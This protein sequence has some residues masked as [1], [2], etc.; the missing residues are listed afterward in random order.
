MRGGSGR[1]SSTL[2]RRS[3][4]EPRTVAKVLA[5]EGRSCTSYTSHSDRALENVAELDFS[6]N[7]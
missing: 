1:R 6:E 2:L 7:L 4:L 3:G 5:E